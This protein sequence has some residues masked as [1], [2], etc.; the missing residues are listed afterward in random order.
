MSAA[1]TGHRGRGRSSLGAARALRRGCR[2]LWTKLVARHMPKEISRAGSRIACS[3]PAR[4]YR[5]TPRFVSAGRGCG[6]A[7]KMEE[8]WVSRPVA[9][10]ERRAHQQLRRP[11]TW[12][13]APADHGSGSPS[14]SPL[15]PLSYVWEMGH[16]RGC[17]RN[18]ACFP[19]MGALTVQWPECS[20]A[21]PK[22]HHDD[23][24][25]GGL[26]ERIDSPASRSVRADRHG[27]AVVSP[28]RPIAPA[29]RETWR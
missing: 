28:P 29:R 4:A 22:V 26:S 9:A 16:D 17:Y 3:W 18:S 7:T 6:L 2:V 8:R 20:L 15:G 14:A 21:L 13:K 19:G 23:S 10:T 11:C 1:R 12:H 5:R 24:R 25:E 27:G